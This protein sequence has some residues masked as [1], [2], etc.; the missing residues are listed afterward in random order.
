MR[1]LKLLGSLSI[2]FVVPLLVLVASA[3]PG[4]TDGKGGH[5]DHSTGE[6]HYHHGHS[7]H[8]HY[9]MDGDGDLDCPY[10]F[11]DKTDSKNDSGSSRNENS[12]TNE[13]PMPLLG[14]IIAFGIYAFF[15]FILPSLIR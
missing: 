7:A 3:H 2:L 12:K 8:D 15:M 13:D 6:Y 11:K 9:D 10:N 5:T 4:G 14:G 1:N